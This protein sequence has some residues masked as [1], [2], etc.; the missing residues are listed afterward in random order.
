VSVALT[1]AALRAMKMTPEAREEALGRCSEE[2]RLKL[3]HEL[4]TI[5]WITLACLV[6]YEQGKLDD[7]FTFLK[8]RCD[9]KK[10]HESV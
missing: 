8:E 6:W 2:I 5:E 7:M 9:G 1:E 4:S 10:N 3:E